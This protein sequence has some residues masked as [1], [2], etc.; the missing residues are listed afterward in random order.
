[1]PKC[2]QSLLYEEIKRHYKKRVFWVICSL[3]G[4][5]ML[6]KT[7]KSLCKG[8]QNNIAKNVSIGFFLTPYLP[9]RKNACKTSIMVKQNSITKRI[10]F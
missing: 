4:N 10:Y 8:I 1:M 2:N 6:K 7:W 5:K 3:L 9:K